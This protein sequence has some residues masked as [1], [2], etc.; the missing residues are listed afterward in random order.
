MDKLRAWWS[1]RQGL[2]GSLA[3][4]TP[5]AVL[6]RSG[7]ARSVG[8]VSPYLTL[9]SRAGISRPDADAAADR[10]EVYELP[11][12]RG[13][14]YVVPAADF[15]LARYLGRHGGEAELKV[16]GRLGVDRA[17]VDRLCERV[18][19]ALA[20]GP[21]D[22]AELRDR[23]GGAVRSLGDEGRKRG[24][25]TTLPAALG[26]LQAEGRILR[27]P[28]NGRLDTQRYAY[29]LWSAPVFDG[30]EADARR[31]LARRYWTWTGAATMAQFREF[32]LFAV[33]DLK[34]VAAELGLVALDGDLLA[35]P[36]LAGEY[37][38]FT[39]PRKPD[40][41]LVGSID[42]LAL[43]RRDAASLI[44][45]ADQVALGDQGGL[46]EV[47]HNLIVDRGRVVGLWQFD[48]DAGELVWWAFG[49][50][51]DAAL[52]AAVADTER[53][54]RDDL[55]DARTFS[56]DSPKSRAPRLAF[57]RSKA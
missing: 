39:R 10:R 9:F 54:V 51:P 40:Y 15:A 37:A 27:M 34:T 12:V 48:P 20:G 6:E 41:R 45:P 5:A 1:A 46:G 14:T 50:K 38:V 36:E 3:G 30:D 22:P 44:E 52:R 57:L 21:L 19:D 31:E 23:L 8:G 47:T 49:A 55:G 13:C 4:A 2:D 33:R 25:S 35:L 32:S 18:L 43:H 53:Y 16:L 26:L 17:E 29:T 7:W 28:L 56:L 42:S 24:S 11:C